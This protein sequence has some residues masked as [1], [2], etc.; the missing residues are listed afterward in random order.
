MAYT[1]R[2]K[3]AYGQTY[4]ARVVTPAKRT[5]VMRAI[6]LA[7]RQRVRQQSLGQ[8]I[9]VKY[10]DTSLVASAIPNVADASS[11]EKNPSATICLNSITQ[12]DGEQQRDGRKATMKSIYINGRVN[13][14]RQ[15]TQALAD[16]GTNII[17]CLVKDTQTNGALLNSEDVFANPSASA[18]LGSS[19]FRNLKFTKR[20]QV[21]ASVKLTFGNMN[22]V[23]D[24][25]ATGNTNQS[26][27][28]QTFSMYKKLGF[29]TLYSAATETIA[30]ITDNS[31]SMIA[32]CDN[33][34]LAPTISYNSRLRFVG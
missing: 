30:N 32:Y 16:D 15:T 12:G 4:M 19:L 1:G 34:E 27:T 11:G 7:V 10:Y 3:R 5:R 18:L 6:P 23:N 2:R 17:I 14:P 24:T 28:T 33:G 13:I 9:E 26:G 29:S 25:G 21:L 22:M 20:F 31:L 8:G